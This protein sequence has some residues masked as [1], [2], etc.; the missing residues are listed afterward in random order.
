MPKVKLTERDVVNIRQRVA[1]L[2][3]NGG[4]NV[5]ETV[6]N[7]FGISP[8]N[9]YIIIRGKTWKSAGGPTWPNG[10]RT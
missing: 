3:K 9:V 4:K 10:F 6:A 8:A 5:L 2:R 1:Y 7:E